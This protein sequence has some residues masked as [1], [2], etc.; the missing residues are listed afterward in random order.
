MGPPTSQ[1]DGPSTGQRHHC[2]SSILQEAAPVSD[3]ADRPLI[4]YELIPSTAL[5][6]EEGSYP[7]G[8]LPNLGGI[9]VQSLRAGDGLPVAV[10]GEGPSEGPG[11]SREPSITYAAT[12]MLRSRV[13]GI[14]SG[15]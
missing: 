7:G 11:T 15:A 9:L 10:R 6:A 2:W 5:C 14:P 13:S 4:P 3:A 8:S 12:P 1:G